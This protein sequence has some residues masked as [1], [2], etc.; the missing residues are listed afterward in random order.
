MITAATTTK[1]STS[2]KA[3][4][5]LP[6]VP[7]AIG[8]IKLSAAVARAESNF[9]KRIVTRHGGKF[10]LQFMVNLFKHHPAG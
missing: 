2:V 8:I 5:N 9:C 10:S 3:D 4:L 7:M 1:S 6:S